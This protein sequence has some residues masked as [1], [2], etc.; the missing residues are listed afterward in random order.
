[1][2]IEILGVNAIVGVRFVHVKKPELKIY[3]DRF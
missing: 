1:M 2:D 3:V